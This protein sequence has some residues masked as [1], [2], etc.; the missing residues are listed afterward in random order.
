MAQH[1][2]S[3]EPYVAE[4]AVFVLGIEAAAV[5]RARDVF[6]WVGQNTILQ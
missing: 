5:D 4:C 6:E 1:L 2:C 3:T